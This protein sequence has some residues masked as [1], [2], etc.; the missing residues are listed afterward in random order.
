MRLNLRH[1][2]RRKETSNLP[3]QLHRIRIYCDYNFLVKLNAISLRTVLCCYIIAKAL[4]LVIP[5]R[6][7]YSA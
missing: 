1:G 7:V 3:S 4:R 5:V 2:L 6:D